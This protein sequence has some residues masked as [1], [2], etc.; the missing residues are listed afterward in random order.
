MDNKYANLIGIA[1]NEPDVYETTSVPPSNDTC[2]VQEDNSNCIQK[3]VISTKD[4]HNKFNAKSLNSDYVDFSDT[5]TSRRK[6][7]YRVEPDAYEWNQDLVESPLQRFKRLEAELTNLKE[8]LKEMDE[9]A[10]EED[11]KQ[12]IDFDPVNLSKQVDELQ[13]K[14]KTLHLETIGAKVD[15]DK[16]NN[17]AK[18]DLLYDN[19]SASKKDLDKKEK[20]KEGQDES[21][22]VFKVFSDLDA[23]DLARVNKISELNQ[24]L[25]NLETVFGAGNAAI[26]ERQIAKL[27]PNIENK[28]ILGLVE[29][30]NAKINLVE[31]QSLEQTESRLQAVLHRM[32]QL[33]EKKS[34]IDDQEKLNHINE[35][36][37]MVS[38]WKE[39]S[40]VVPSIVERLAALNEI[41]QRAFEFPAI[42]SRLDTEQES[43]KQNLNSSSDVLKNLEKSL[44]TNMESIRSNFSV[45]NERIKADVTA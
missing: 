12:L 26:N 24:R 13:A 40:S 9:F 2:P 28:S 36:Y 25:A 39:I 6:F 31:R 29:N 30:L 17:K 42:L 16:L 41:H 33:N 3:I 8:D 44:E 38:K 19:L 37:T 35:L 34:V 15:V 27:C 45:L 23:N 22:I 10:S 4:A 11:K 21:G 7:G 32:N 1:R 14:V 20:S 5:I 43:I 18:R